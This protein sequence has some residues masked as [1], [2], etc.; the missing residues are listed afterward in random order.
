MRLSW[1]ARIMCSREGSI[2]VLCVSV[3]GYMIEKRTT[4]GEIKI[5]NH[6][7]AKFLSRSEILQSCFFK[8]HAVMKTGSSNYSSLNL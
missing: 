5:L 3:T 7:F 1:L 8:L 6:F 2:W 4:L